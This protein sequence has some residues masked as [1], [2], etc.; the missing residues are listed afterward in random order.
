M[1]KNSLMGIG[2]IISCR[3]L[4]IFKI[5]TIKFLEAVRNSI[6]LKNLKK[7]VKTELMESIDDIIY[8][9]SKNCFKK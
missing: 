5:A 8:R 6:N 1:Q 2:K 3:E 7:Q 9:K 4:L